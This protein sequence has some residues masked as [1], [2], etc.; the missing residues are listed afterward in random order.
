MPGYNTKTHRPHL[1]KKQ[2]HHIHTRDNH[3]CQLQYPGCTGTPDQIDH[4]IPLSQGGTHTT[5]NLQTVCTNCHQQKTRK[6]IQWGHQQHH[7]RAKHPPEPHP[8]LK[9]TPHTT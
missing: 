7:N 1:T 5:N 6:E 9:T 8:G 3:T 4:K 2:K